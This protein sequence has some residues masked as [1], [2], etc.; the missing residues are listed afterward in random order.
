MLGKDRRICRK[1]KWERGSRWDS[2]LISRI[3]KEDL[4]RKLDLDD[5]ENNDGLLGKSSGS[6]KKIGISSII[7]KHQEIRGKIFVI[8]K[9]KSKG[10]RNWAVAVE[11][12][13]VGIFHICLT[14]I[15]TILL[16]LI[17]MIDPK[18]DTD[19]GR[20]GIN[21]IYIWAK[22]L[23]IQNHYKKNDEFSSVD[24]TNDIHFLLKYDSLTFWLF[25]LARMAQRQLLGS[26]G[27]K[28]NGQGVRKRLKVLV[29]RFNNLDLIKGYSKTLIGRCMNPEEQNIKYLPGTL[30]KIW[31]LE[32]M[33]IGTDLGLG[34]FQFVFD[35]EADIESVLKMQHFHFDYWMI[36]LVRWQPR[37]SRNYPFEITFWIKVLGFP[38]QFWKEPTFRSIGDAIGETKAI[39][40]DNGR[41]QVMVD[42]FKELVFETSVDFTGGEY[43][44]EQE[45][46]VSLKY[47]KLFGY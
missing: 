20:S 32:E 26:S 45:V 5:K 46:P 40:L 44:E 21:G 31:N 10:F 1:S 38:L 17:D 42:G 15:I 36:S 33:V 43:Y 2:R 22:G 7:K 4:Q 19:S 37:K 34:N 35:E 6:G 3:G 11:A 14:R 29:P 30:P 9:T 24:I 47:E 18:D 25:F 39:D 28:E 23:R 12:W 16:F 27:E 13:K 41:I 8:F